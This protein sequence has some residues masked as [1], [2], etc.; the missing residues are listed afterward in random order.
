MDRKYVIVCNKHKAMW[1]GCLLFWGHLTYDDESRSFGGYTSDLERCERYTLEEIQDEHYTFPIYDEG[2]MTR[3]DFLNC[4]DIVISI[5]QLVK[6]GY[7]FMKVA[8]LK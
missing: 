3:R 5:P 1:N 8:Y 6:L 2:T 4:E 7:G